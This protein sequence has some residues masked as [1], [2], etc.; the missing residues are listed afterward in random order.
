MPAICV[1][2]LLVL[3]AGRTASADI[4]NPS[5]RTVNPVFAFPGVE[6]HPDHVFL[7]HVRDKSYWGPNVPFE[8]RTIPVTGPTDFQ[9][10]FNKTIKSVALLAVPRGVYDGWSPAE[11]EAV[12]PDT[13]GVLSCDIA[14]PAMSRD[15]REPEPPPYR[16]RVALDADR[17]AVEKLPADDADGAAA[18]GSAWPGGGPWWGVGLAAVTIWLGFVAA[19][20]FLGTA[21]AAASRSRA[22]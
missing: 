15:V 20:R 2:I 11:R 18:G 5:Q 7:L 17:L 14:P 10:G 1:A 12:A 21:N 3:G 8:P 4:A 6:K 9:P 13:P 16:Y 22:A 19:R